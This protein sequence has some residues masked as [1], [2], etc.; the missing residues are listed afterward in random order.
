MGALRRYRY[1]LVLIPYFMIA[2]IPFV[3]RL[4]P[5]VF[6]LPFLW[7]W[8]FMWAVLITVLITILYLIE[9]KKP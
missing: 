7:F 9:V 5:R 8:F 6:G 3:N 4:E 2:L 1:I